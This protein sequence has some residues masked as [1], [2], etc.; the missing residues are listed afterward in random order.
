MTRLACGVT[1]RPCSFLVYF[2][3]DLFTPCACADSFGTTRKAI[4]PG[5]SGGP[6]F[7]DE[8]R[9]V[10]V[11]FQG[12]EGSDAQNVGYIIPS[13]VVQNFLHA[14]GFGQSGAASLE[15]DGGD[16]SGTSA[17]HT[18][19]GADGTS[20]TV[21]PLKYEGVQ[22]VPFRWA[23]LQNKSLRKLLNMP[24]ESTGV[25][26]TRVS[27]L[28]AKKYDAFL[29]ENDVITHIDGRSIGDDYTVSLRQDEL[30]NA[31]FL[32]TG[33]RRGDP[34]VFDVIRDTEPL[35]ICVTLGPLPSNVPREHNLDC[36]PEWLV[37]GGLLFVPLTCPLL[38][39]GSTEELEASGYLKIYDFID[40]EVY[41]FREVEGKESI[42][43]IDILTCD[44]NFGY[45]FRQS[46][47]V[48]ETLNGEKVSNM[49]HLYSLYKK[50]CGQ[51]AEEGDAAA[52][53]PAVKGDGDGNGDGTK[54]AETT[55]TQSASVAGD[56]TS[57]DFLIFR[58]K[59]KSRIVLGTADCMASEKEILEQ[60][61]ISTAVS[62]GIIK[63]AEAMEQ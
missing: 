43:L 49:A 36:T 23:P 26:V 30:M 27:P 13:G 19:A 63:G 8:G 22:E 25:V 59:D 37:I 28:A 45:Y 44:T 52:L 61:G 15:A 1:V 33:K 60:H 4:N 29:R 9:V 24:K 17:S 56:S 34:T 54:P 21:V 35:K 39:Y 32:I 12:L 48:L 41:K 10:G 38:S 58:F 3:R 5:N 57:G 50:A 7:D 16:G 46:W 6:C 31:D 40:D 62:A 18:D 20:H 11:A 2:P 55:S 42:L 53:T 14:V 47:R 51:V